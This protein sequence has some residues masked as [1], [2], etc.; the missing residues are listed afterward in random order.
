M[1][2]TNCLAGIQCPQCGQE[3]RFK[4]TAM[5]TYLVTD[6]GSDPGG[7]HEWDDNSFTLCCECQCQGPLKVF[8][9][10][11]SLPP[12]PES[13][14]ENRAAWARQALAAFIAAT[15]ADWDDALA[16]LLCD[17]MH[18]CDRCGVAFDC[19]MARAKCHYEAETASEPS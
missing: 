17:L 5:V 3:D 13:M 11:A 10:P 8:R 18:L 7:D 16:D 1:P 15:G 4:I 9:S 14:N 6:E 19:E 12:D 2:N